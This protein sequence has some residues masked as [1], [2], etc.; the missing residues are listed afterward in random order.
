MGFRAGTLKL[1]A[2]GWCYWF[3]GNKRVLQKN[4]GPT[5]VECIIFFFARLKKPLCQQGAHRGSWEELLDI[6]SRGKEL[7]SLLVSHFPKETE[8]HG[9]SSWLP[10]D[11]CQICKLA[12]SWGLAL[13]DS[14]WWRYPQR[15]SVGGWVWYSSK[16]PRAHD[17]GSSH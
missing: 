10:L 3:Q 9:H 14:K 2:C 1:P 15:C 5:W 13:Q 7:V 17:A 4:W 6:S 8:F 12:D 16:Q 11:S